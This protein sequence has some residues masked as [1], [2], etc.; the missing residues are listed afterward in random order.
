M[1]IKP[2]RIMTRD[3]A[4]VCLAKTGGNPSTSVRFIASPPDLGTIGCQGNI[5]WRV[6]ARNV[7]DSYRGPLKEIHDVLREMTL[8]MR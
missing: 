8:S 7:L 6:R 4:T 5:H 3:G 2:N 1:T